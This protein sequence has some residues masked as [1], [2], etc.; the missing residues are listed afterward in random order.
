MVYE[1]QMELNRS[2]YVEHSSGQ[3]LSFGPKTFCEAEVFGG[4]GDSCWH[5]VALEFLETARSVV[6]A[7]DHAQETSRRRELV[8]HR[9]QRLAMRGA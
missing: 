3:A 7:G 8:E 1:I 6:V 9:E 2:L 5:G 4:R